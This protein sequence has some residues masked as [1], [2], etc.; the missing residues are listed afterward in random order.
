MGWL[1]LRRNYRSAQRARQIANVFLRHGFGSVI[2]QIQLGRFIPFRKRL[3]NFG[4][5]EQPRGLSV[6]ER[7][8]MS[9]GELGPSF[10]K[11]AQILSARPDLVTPV[12]ANEFKK[13]QDSVPPFSF[14][15]ARQII[16]EDTGQT[17]AGLF[18]D[19]EDKPIAAASIAQV[20]RA[21]LKNGRKVIVKVRRPGIRAQI[22][23]D[24]EILKVIARLME[25]NIPESRFFNPIGLVKEFA[26]TV[27]KELDFVAEAHNC[28]RLKHNLE[29]LTDV[30]IP[31]VFREYLSERMIVM[32]MVEG[33][34]MDDIKGIEEMGYTGA[35]VC[36]SMMNAYLKMILEDGFFH[37]DPHP[38]NIFVTAEGKICLMDFGIVGR[39][40]DETREIIANTFLALI[41]KDFDTLIE[42]YISLGYLPEDADEAAFR[43]EFKEDL[44]DLIEPLYSVPVKEI[45]F[46]RTMEVILQ[47][48]MRHRLRIPSDMLIINK[49]LLVMEGVVRDIDPEFNF[50]AV[51]EPY[52]K[53]M[54][55]RKFSPRWAIQK[56]LK[57]I[58]GTG[59][60][61]L[62]M[63]RDINKLL[64]KAIK[65]DIGIKMNLHGLD[66]FIRD[67]DRSSNRIAFAL[68]IS[69]IILS[70]SI[71]FLSGKGPA[72]Y[73]LPIFGFLGFGFAFLLGVWLLISILRSGRL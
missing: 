42:S 33:V 63:P 6:P 46:A 30:Y 60:I 48:A 17:I 26:R 41:N 53:A 65:N 14:E 64:K 9:F 29:S 39:V 57:E 12:Y 5:W 73:G 55:S 34:R 68:V 18:D 1:S 52:A 36:H 23:Q 49:T 20:H 45:D 37:G 35:G 13:L 51:T 44:T 69:A 10:I 22:E 31:E 4:K 70:S 25:N 59:D 38:G 72:M 71:M 16:E 8:R 11:M 66:Q 24:I 47:S 43:R 61:L 3:R 21:R 19:F 28:I 56:A 27:T 15:E 50:I 58:S 54:L 62:G 40:N 2:D 7:L 32:E 67:M